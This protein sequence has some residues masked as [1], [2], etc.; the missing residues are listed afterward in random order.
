MCVCNG[1]LVCVRARWGQGFES[2]KA[3]VAAM[4][5]ECFAKAD[6]NGDGFLDFEEFKQAVSHN[7]LVI[8]SFWSQGIH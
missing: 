6:E 4:V 3:V 7:A 8:Q 2:P 5:S 1:L